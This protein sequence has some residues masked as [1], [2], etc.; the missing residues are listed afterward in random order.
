[1]YKTSMGSE[2]QNV[3]YDLLQVVKSNKLIEARYSLTLQEQRLLL[4]LQAHVDPED[5]DFK[6][7]H[8]DVRDFCSMVGVRGGDYYA[9]IKDITLGMLGKTFVIPEDDGDL[10]VGFF[11]SA[12]YLDKK[13]KVAI[14]FDP[15]L[16]PYLLGLKKEY[17]KYKLI[18]VVQL[19]S[20][21]S[22]RLYELL[23]QYEFLGNRRFE[24][25]ELRR[26]LEVPPTLYP[27]YSKFKDVCLVKQLAEI[28]Q[29]TDLSITYEEIKKNQKH[30][31]AI[32]F[33]I[34]PNKSYFKK[35]QKEMV[36]EIP[37][38]ITE[39]IPDAY[40]SQVIGIV[41]QYI[42]KEG[43]EYVKRAIEYTNSMNYGDYRKYLSSVLVHNYAKDWV[44]NQLELFSKDGL[45]AHEKGLKKT[46]EEIA[47]AKEKSE[48]K[49]KQAFSEKALALAKEK[50]AGM[51]AEER[52]ELK[53][54]V[55]N[56]NPALK[57]K[58]DI[59]H[60]MLIHLKDDI[61]RALI[62][63]VMTIPEKNGNSISAE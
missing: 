11:S 52:D 56:G 35:H 46:A 23:K 49:L 13:G 34:E 2:D 25:P 27:R 47:K 21:Y 28:N 45:K 63:Q 44:P 20:I 17:T 37:D 59:E 4:W 24:I 30:V 62:E 10:Q 12:K 61:E 1:M 40:L 14:R 15:S 48:L 55:I 32:V 58:V 22:V 42:L 7:I 36:R 39:L 26:L 19:R 5:E 18:I 8:L 57:K 53:R 6:E 50:L 29:K 3:K 31:E 60:F 38:Y 54:I 41:Y 51:P 33:T 43:P 16:K 9:E